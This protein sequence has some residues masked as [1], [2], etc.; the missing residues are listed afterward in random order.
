MR[1]LKLQ[2]QVTLDGFN[3]TGPN[4]EQ[5]WVTW[6]LDCVRQYVIDLLDTSD[7]ILIGRKL[8]VDYIPFWQETVKN[9]DDPMFEF[10]T[11]I[12]NAKKIVFT[13]T[14]G[15]SIWDKTELAS[16]N[17]KEEIN[18][19]KSQKGKDII[20]YGGSSFVSALI[21]EGLIDEFHFFINPIA[22]G[23]GVSPFGQLNNWQQLKFKNSITCAS[24]LIILHY[25]RQ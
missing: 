4:D 21:R 12:V 6:D 20:V 18:K 5:Q 16:G 23:K 7:T 2:M 10:A 24:G 22:I 14:L 17:L 15:N 3:S 11:R 19:L 13:K 25:E 9:P 1:K 8:A